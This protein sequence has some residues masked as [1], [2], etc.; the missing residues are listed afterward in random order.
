VRD[1]ERLLSEDANSWDAV[2]IRGARKADAHGKRG[3]SRF[4]DAA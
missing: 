2:P 1:A 3:E 4:H